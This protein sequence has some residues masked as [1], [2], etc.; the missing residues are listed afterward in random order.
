MDMLKSAPDWT[1]LRAFLTTADSGS[2]S[3]AA[4]TL[5]L[6]QPTLSRQ[7][8]ALEEQLGVMLFERVGRRLDLTDAGRELLP[9]ARDMGQAA[10]RVA[11]SASGQRSE[12]SGQVRI[13]ASDITAVTFLPKVVATLRK[14]AP[15]LMIDVVASNDIQDLMR[16]EA[17]IAIRHQRPEQPDLVARLVLDAVGHF[18]ASKPYLDQ[19]GHPTTRAELAKHDWVSFGDVDRMVSYMVAMDIPVTPECFRASSENGMVAWEL[20]R[21]GL[22]ICPMDVYHGA[23]APDMEAIMPADLHVTFPIWLVTH[24]EIH[25]SPR[26]R[27]VYDLLAE[28]IAAR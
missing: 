15:Q 7:V 13:T 20:A 22:G 27:L 8:A 17:D 16:R 9:H 24:R 2:L 14:A 26:I 19:R 6:T 11:L 21:A 3:A 28:A 12:I 10:Q 18:Y 5:G 1:H 23:R 4:R 25:T